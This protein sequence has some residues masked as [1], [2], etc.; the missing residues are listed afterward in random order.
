[1]E[2]A[3][4]LPYFGDPWENPN[5]LEAFSD[6]KSVAALVFVLYHTVEET[7]RVAYCMYEHSAKKIKLSIFVCQCELLLILH[8]PHGRLQ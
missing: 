7:I 8:L 1:M 2:R 3:I 5:I 4:N 6:Q